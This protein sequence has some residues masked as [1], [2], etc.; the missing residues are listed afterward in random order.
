MQAKIP[1]GQTELT[2]EVHTEQGS[3]IDCIHPKEVEQRE[4]P[5]NLWWFEHCSTSAGIS[6]S[7]LT[8][9]M[10]LLT[11]EFRRFNSLSL[12]ASLVPF[13]SHPFTT[14]LL[15]CFPPFPS[16]PLPFPLPLIS[17]CFTGSLPPSPEP[18]CKKCNYPEAPMLDRQNVEST[19]KE[20]LQESLLFQPPD[21]H[22]F[23]PGSRNMSKEHF[24]MNLTL[25]G[26][27]ATS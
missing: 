27:P 18:P 9:R 8:S 23:S 13:L 11:S 21:A 3:L 25:T 12:P 22:I 10:Q 16:P 24:N 14:S 1:V 6:D 26:A 20:M 15:F 2:F 4:K 19:L 7:L 17:P 5:K